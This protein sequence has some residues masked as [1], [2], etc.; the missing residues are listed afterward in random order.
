MR[1]IALIFIVTVSFWADLAGAQTSSDRPK[2]DAAASIGLLSANPAPADD[3]YGGDWY[4]E[5]RYAASIGRYWTEH[6]KT[7][8][9]LMTSTEGER[10]VQH[11]STVPGVPP[12]YTYTAHERHTLRQVSG[13]MVWQFFDNAWVHPYVFGGV[14]VDADR[15]EIFVPPQYYYPDPRSP[16]SQLIAAPTANGAPETIRR[17]GVNAGVGAKIYITRNG[18]FNAAL[19]VSH[20]K[21]A[22][23]ASIVGGFGIDF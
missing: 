17:V 18:F 14:S 19:V 9:E 21:P 16:A 23:T 8:L 15:R 22:R 6:L 1:R 5:G 20:A 11:Y 13:R 12:F 7:E 10:H 2:W 4:F 3:P